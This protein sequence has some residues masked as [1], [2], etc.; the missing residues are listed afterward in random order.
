[1]EAVKQKLN[2]IGEEFAKISFIKKAAQKVGVQ[3]GVLVS[4]TMAVVILLVAFGL[5]GRFIVST[6]GFLYPAYRSFKAIESDDHDDDTQWLTY[7]V[8]YAFFTVFD[9]MTEWI[10]GIIPFY[11][12]IKLLFYIWMFWPSTNGAQTIYKTILKPFLIKYQS[13]IDK[14][15]ERFEEGVGDTI[16]KV[17]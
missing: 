7:W 17:K 15:V 6:V 1:M 10:L 11:H 4:T 3:P 16:S 2:E 9:D 8:V 5:G 12:L 13:D 14:Q